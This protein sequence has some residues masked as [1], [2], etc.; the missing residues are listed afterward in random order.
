MDGYHPAV[1]EYLETILELEESGI[2]PMRAR[3]VERLGVSAPAVS[4]TVRRLEREGYLT[5]DESRAIRLTTKG[6]H[7]ATSIMRRHRLAERLLTDVMK[8]PW[9]QV[10]EEAGR[11]EH[12]I[13]PRLE[14][15]LVALLG[16]PGTCPHG[17]PIP[18]SVN[19]VD[20]ASQ[21]PLATA[22]PG[23]TI[24]VRRIDEELEAQFDRMQELESI[25]VMPGR[26]LRVLGH[27]GPGQQRFDSDGEVITLDRMV[28]AKVYVT[29][30]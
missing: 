11:L 22:A 15:H 26:M 17:N 16:D 6:R 19:A 9:S 21:V 27:E 14:A 10:H 20:V 24:V 25:K 28:T 30:E 12:A 3:I 5:L 4:E 23:S 1:E 2:R 18:G 29:L 13:S 7:Y 8:V